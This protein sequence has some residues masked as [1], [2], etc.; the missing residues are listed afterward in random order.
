MNDFIGLVGV[1]RGSGGRE[2]DLWVTARLAETATA[3]IGPAFFSFAAI[4]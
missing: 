4:F 3:S 2:P 1:M